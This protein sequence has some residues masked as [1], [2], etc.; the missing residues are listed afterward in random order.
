[1]RP[2][3]DQVG[4]SFRTRSLRI[5]VDGVEMKLKYCRVC[6]I[7]RPPRTCHCLVCDNCVERFDHHCLWIGQCIGLRNYRYYMMF[8]FS[9]LVFFIYIFTFSCWRIRRKITEG[10]S[11]MF[12]VLGN[13]PETVALALFSFTAMWFLG[14]L[15]VFHVYLTAL[16]QTAHENYKRRYTRSSNPFD[17]GVLSNIKEILF[18]SLGPSRVNFRAEVEPEYG[19]IARMLMNSNKLSKEADVEIE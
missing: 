8:I 11:G 5:S 13:V 3:S 2:M 6:M 14:G 4:T 12:Q 16:N 9:A 18:K 15:V 7:Y 10:G 17:K 19:Y 1:M